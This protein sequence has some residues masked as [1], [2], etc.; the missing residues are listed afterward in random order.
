MKWG[1]NLYSPSALIVGGGGEPSSTAEFPH[2]AALGYED[3]ENNETY[4]GCGGSLI[5]LKFVL[6]AAHCLNSLHLGP[7]KYVRLGDLNLRTTDDEADPQDF[8]VSKTYKHP[9]YKRPVKYHDI[10][11]ILLDRAAVI[12]KYVQPACLNINLNTSNNHLVATGWGLL[13]FQGNAADHLQK[14]DLYQVNNNDCK[15]AYEVNRRVL[16]EGILEQYQI[17]AGYR[18]RDTCQG[19]SGGPLQSRTNLR[20]YYIH[21]V[22]SFGKACLL[23]NSPGVYTRVANYIDWI[24][25][26]VWPNAK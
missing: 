15:K 3:T 7:V 21:G 8:L 26:I 2:M 5:S 4:W 11:L 19:D 6:T 12:T 20:N 14:L 16:S 25:S 24:E 23:T 10:A 18:G 17:C 22:T 1:P 9:L 13:S